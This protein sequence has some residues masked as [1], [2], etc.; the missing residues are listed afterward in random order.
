M[1]TVT[2][3]IGGLPI[4]VPAGSL[5]KPCEFGDAVVKAIQNQSN[6]KLSTAKFVTTDLAKANAVEYALD[7]YMGGHEI[8]VDASG[9][10]IEFTVWSKGYYHHIG[11]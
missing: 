5:D 10:D 8:E 4:A 9:E 2:K 3:K 7:W 1:Q 6:W 11:A